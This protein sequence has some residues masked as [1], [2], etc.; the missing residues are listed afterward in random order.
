MTTLSSLAM[1]IRNPKQKRRPI[2]PTP[3]ER[4]MKSELL[5]GEPKQDRKAES[6]E[7]FR[8]AGE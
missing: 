2:H 3:I 1:S 6:S 5:I 4:Q 7:R 8:K